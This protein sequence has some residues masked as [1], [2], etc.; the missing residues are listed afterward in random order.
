MLRTLKKNDKFAF[1]GDKSTVVRRTFW[2][3][4]MVPTWKKFEKRWCRGLRH[5]K[6]IVNVKVYWVGYVIVMVNIKMFHLGFIQVL[7]TVIEI[8]IL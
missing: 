4:K 3:I 8:S 2:L 7:I 5:K 6:V 1:R